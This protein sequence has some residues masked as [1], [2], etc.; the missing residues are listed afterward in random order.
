MTSPAFDMITNAIDMNAKMRA[1]IDDSGTSIRFHTALRYRPRKTPS[2]ATSTEFTDGTG[3]ERGDEAKWGAISSIQHGASACTL[4]HECRILH[5]NRYLPEAQLVEEVV[6][7]KIPGFVQQSAGVVAVDGIKAGGRSFEE[8][9]VGDKRVA[10]LAPV[11]FRQQHEPV[12]EREWTTLEHRLRP[13]KELLTC[14]GN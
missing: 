13:E 8:V 4:P 14:K 6:D 5:L 9:R 3:D 2:K 7:A 12:K 10:H 1:S 11:S